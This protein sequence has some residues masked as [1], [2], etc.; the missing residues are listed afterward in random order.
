ML[1]YFFWSRFERQVRVEGSVTENFRRG[2]SRNILQRVR[3]KSQI[4]AWASPQSE[5]ISGREEL[6]RDRQNSRRLTVT[7]PCPGQNIG[8]AIA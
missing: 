5:V 3:V 1:P 4:G 7:V 2:V 8:A 6:E